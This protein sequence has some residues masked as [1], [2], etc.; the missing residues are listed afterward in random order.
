MAQMDA[1]ALIQGLQATME[2]LNVAISAQSLGSFVDK[3]EG[4]PKDFKGWVRSVEKYSLLNNLDDRRKINTAFLA[5]K[6]PVSD[7]IFRWTTDTDGDQQTWDRLKQDLTVRFS[8]VTDAEHASTLLKKIKQGP[9]RSVQMFAEEIHSLA[10]ITY[11][12]LHGAGARAAIERQL[13]STFIDGLHSDSIKW[14]IMRDAPTTFERAV[15]LAMDEQN[16]RKRFNVRTGHSEEYSDVKR[17][18][19]M[20]VDHTRAR[21]RCHICQRVGHRARDCRQAR[22]VNLVTSNNLRLQPEP[23][24]NFQPRPNHPTQLNGGQATIICW[25]CQRPGH[26]RRHCE[27]L[28][29]QMNRMNMSEPVVRRSQQAQEN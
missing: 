23:R 6:G 29:E 9:N 18:T 4:E 13:I 20:E 21:I 14:K 11:R 15:T 16:L 5:S 27:Q 7:Y 1:N 10:E 12:G 25:H 17:H 8:L 22:P 26:I 24:H 28:R 3:Y 19:P 2:N